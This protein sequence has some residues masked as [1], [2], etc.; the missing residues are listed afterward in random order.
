MMEPTGSAQPRLQK[1]MP[2]SAT[3]M[4]LDHALDVTELSL[5]ETLEAKFSGN[6]NIIYH[7]QNT[8]GRKMRSWSARSRLSRTETKNSEGARELPP[9]PVNARGFQRASNRARA[10]RKIARLKRRAHGPENHADEFF[11]HLQME[12]EQKG[13]VSLKTFKS[14][15]RCHLPLQRGEL[16]A[17]IYLST[18]GHSNPNISIKAAMLALEKPKAAPPRRF[19]AKERT[20][21]KTLARTMTLLK[22]NPTKKPAMSKFVLETNTAEAMRAMLMTRKLTDRGRRRQEFRTWITANTVKVGKRI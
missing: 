16:K 8:K 20:Y 15:A 10:S 13:C 19:D 5:S 11:R 21:S 14:I 22:Q 4:P 2:T 1:K 3:D 7:P 9:N 17:L 6:N 18:S 12:H